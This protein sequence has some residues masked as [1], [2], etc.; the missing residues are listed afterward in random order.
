MSIHTS[1]EMD[2]YSVARTA[3]HF[4]CSS[5]DNFLA[6]A[7]D[8]QHVSFSGNGCCLTNAWRHGFTVQWA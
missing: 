2:A 4:Y 3:R 6:P 8:L 5:A 7:E 1:A